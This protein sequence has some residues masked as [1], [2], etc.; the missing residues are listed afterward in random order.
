MWGGGT[1]IFISAAVLPQADGVVGEQF[2]NVSC[3]TV[4]R[5]LL[6]SVYVPFSDRVGH[7][8]HNILSPFL[9]VM[10]VFS[11]DL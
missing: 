2:Y 7:P 4:K 3:E 11:V 9:P 1:Q 5:L 6:L 8:L 10:N